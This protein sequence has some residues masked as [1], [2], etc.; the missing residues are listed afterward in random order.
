MRAD[1]RAVVGVLLLVAGA[2]AGCGGPPPAVTARAGVVAHA[3]E[4]VALAYAPDGRT[5]VSRGRDAIKAWNA[6]S[7]RERGSLPSD[8]SDFGTVAVSPDGTAVAATLAGRGIVAWDLATL[9]E[10]ATYHTPAAGGATPAAPEAFGWGLAYSPDGA[11]LAGPADDGAGSSIRLWDVAGR[12]ATGLGPPGSPATHLAFTP[13]GK[14]LI[15][16]GMEGSLRVFDVAGRAERRT[17]DAGLTYLTAIAVSPDGRAVASSGADRYLRLWSVETGA[18]VGRLRGHLKAILGVAFHPDGRHVVT[19]DSAGT[20][21][22]WD[23]PAQRTIAQ[24]AGH[25]GKVWTLAVRPDGRELASAGEDRQIRLWDI[26]K[27]I[28]AYGQ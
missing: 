20:I 2:F 17:I 28:Q 9:A 11:T 27:A 5:L 26:A 21:F 23:I 14:S 25:E 4:I 15:A 7:L 24:F 6:D 12:A 18:E 16:K 10:R 22:L 3:G 19:G 13:D 8:G 1:R